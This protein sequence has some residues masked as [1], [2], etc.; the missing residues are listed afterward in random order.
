MTK[1][2]EGMVDIRN[3]SGEHHGMADSF[4]IR[5]AT[6]DPAI[7]EAL[8]DVLLDCVEG[9]ASVGFMLPLA[10]TKALAFWQ[11]CLASA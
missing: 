1:A 2:G 10:R 3:T 11:G 7:A 9:G 5:C 6:A 4:R 8:A